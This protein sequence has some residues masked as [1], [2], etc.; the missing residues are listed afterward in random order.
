MQ[1][2]AVFYYAIGIVLANTN[3]STLDGY[4]DVF[5]TFS[6]VQGPHFAATHLQHTEHFFYLQL[7]SDVIIRSALTFSDKWRPAVVSE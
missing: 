6:V 7:N 3:L 4:F 5:S 1:D 2:F